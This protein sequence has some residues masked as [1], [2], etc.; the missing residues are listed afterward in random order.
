MGKCFYKNAFCR[1]LV[2]KTKF[3]KKKK[4][5]IIKRLLFINSCT[6]VSKMGTSSRTEVNS[7]NLSNVKRTIKSHL[8]CWLMAI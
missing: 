4:Q 1:W 5:L 2:S 6:P 8:V 7:I 3:E